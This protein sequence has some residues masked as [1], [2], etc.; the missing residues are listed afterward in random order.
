MKKLR[1]LLLVLSFVLLG[2]LWFLPQR[3]A[4]LHPG[5]LV[6]THFNLHGQTDAMGK[7]QDLLVLAIVGSGLFLLFELLCRLDLPINTGYLLD[8]AATGVL[9]ELDRLQLA[10]LRVEVLALL[11]ALAVDCLSSARIVPLHQAVP[12]LALM[13]LFATIF[14]FQLVRTRRCRELSGGVRITEKQ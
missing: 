7:P 10:V 12:F 9:R 11:L 2:L 14:G 1:L 8:E 5:M 4:R 13:V 6:P 3:M